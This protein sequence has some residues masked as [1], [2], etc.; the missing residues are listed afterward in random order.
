MAKELRIHSQ[1]DRDL[2]RL[3]LQGQLCAE[4]KERLEEEFQKWFD[5]GVCSFVVQLHHLDEMSNA[6][7]AVFIGLLRAAQELGGRVSLLRPA[8]AVI[9]CLETHSGL[10]LVHIVSSAQECPS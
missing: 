5:K 10:P 6:G 8:P 1:A 3:D 7:G 4:T 9:R 2:V